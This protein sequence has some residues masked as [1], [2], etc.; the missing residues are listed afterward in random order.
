MGFEYII[1]LI[2]TV[3]ELIEIAKQSN[4]LFLKKLPITKI[5]DEVFQ[6]TNLQVLVINGLKLEKIPSE[7]SKKELMSI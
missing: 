1:I 5:P 3:E 6:L 4:T 7:I 2:V